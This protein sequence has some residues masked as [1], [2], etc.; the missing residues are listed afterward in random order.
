MFQTGRCFE[1]PESHILINQ[2]E[3]VRAKQWFSLLKVMMP[4]HSDPPSRIDLYHGTP[5]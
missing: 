1:N 3:L 5:I 2:G 4:I